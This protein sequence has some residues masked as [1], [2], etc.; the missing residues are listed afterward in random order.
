MTV[1]VSE[2]ISITTVIFKSDDD[3]GNPKL[4]DWLLILPQEVKFI[5]RASWN[6]TTV[7]YLLTRYIP[8][9]SVAFMLRSELFLHRSAHLPPY[10]RLPPRSFFEFVDGN[11]HRV[12]ASTPSSMPE[13]AWNEHPLS[14]HRV[15]KLDSIADLN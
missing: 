12:R 14:F 15:N 8:F 1:L 2:V 9:V 7:L 11:S 5:W 13:P 4:Y 10:S 6:W 3:C